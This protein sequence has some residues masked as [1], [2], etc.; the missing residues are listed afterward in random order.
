MKNLHSSPCP[1]PLGAS[2]D[3]S[4]AGWNSLQDQALQVPGWV[5]N[6]SDNSIV[7]CSNAGSVAV[8]IFSLYLLDKGSLCDPFFWACFPKQSLW[9]ASSHPNKMWQPAPQALHTPVR[10]PLLGAL[11]PGCR[12]TPSPS[13]RREPA[14]PARP[15]PDSAFSLL[16]GWARPPLLL[17]KWETVN[18][19]IP[20][21]GARWTQL[22]SESPLLA[23]MRQTQHSHP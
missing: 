12:M 23:D 10:L 4:F 6:S 21:R 8:A 3:T 14:A 11:P 17:L 22:A 16:A 5:F 2:M 18:A 1:F 9:R 19:F 20:H 15:R 7:Q 13:I